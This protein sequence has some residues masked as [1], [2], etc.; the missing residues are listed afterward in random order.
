MYAIIILM[1]IS[2]SILVA[3]YAIFAAYILYR[4]VFRKDPLKAEYEK[5]YNEVM[6]SDKY[7]VKGQHDK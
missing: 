7:K 3:A 4:L 1:E 2:K 5:L 6:H